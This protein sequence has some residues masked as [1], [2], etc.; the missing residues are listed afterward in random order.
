[1]LTVNSNAYFG[2]AA[3]TGCLHLWATA[4]QDS[5]LCNSG[6]NIAWTLPGS[7]STNQVLSLGAGGQWNFV[8]PPGVVAVL[9]SLVG[10]L[11]NSAAQVIGYTIPANT[12]AAGTTYTIEAY[13]YLSNSGSSSADTFSIELGT[14][15]LSGNVL[16]SSAPNA[17]ASAVGQGLH[18]R[19][20]LTYWGPNVSASVEVCGT[21]STTFTTT[22]VVNY[23]ASATI[24]TTVSNVLELDFL[25]AASTS[26]IHFN[27]ATITLDKP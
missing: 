5:V 17:V 9:T 21:S 26:T 18:L 20:K 23:A 25:S 12:I 22:C 10:P 24:T 8:T 15:T 3:I 7:G 1:M 19:A 13:G 27:V 2:S 11:S 14:T 4:G 16:V 6:S